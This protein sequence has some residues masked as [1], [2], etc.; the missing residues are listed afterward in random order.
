M[1]TKDLSGII[2]ALSANPELM[3]QISQIAKNF[4]KTENTE[5][6]TEVIPDKK[7]EEQRNRER[8]ISALKPYLNP[9]RREKADKLLT[10]LGVIELGKG[11]GIFNNILS[12]Q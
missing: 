3:G 7:S 12:Q 11:S 2:S 6:K 5:Q 1:E 8:L 9:E 4:G 10:F